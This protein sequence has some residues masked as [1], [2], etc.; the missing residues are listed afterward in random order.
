[1]LTR[2]PLRPDDMPYPAS[3]NKQGLGF[4]MLTLTG[5][6]VCEQAQ[7]LHEVLAGDVETYLAPR[8]VCDVLTDFPAAR[9][10]MS[11]VRA[12]HLSTSLCTHHESIVAALFGNPKPVHFLKLDSGVLRVQ[13]LA[14]LRQLQP[15]LYSIS[16]AQAEAPDRV[17]VTVAVVRYDSLGQQRVGVT[18]TLLAERLQVSGGSVWGQRLEFVMNM[19]L[20][21]CCAATH[22]TRV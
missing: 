5:T 21:R 2:V 6:S 18:S 20:W 8:H 11:E 15:R 4:E 10:P 17:Q 3:A 12:C 16:S 1:M 9:L 19:Q 13:V 7:R 22:W 14:G